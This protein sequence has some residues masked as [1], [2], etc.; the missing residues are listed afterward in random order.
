[1][2]TNVNE[3]RIYANRIENIFEPELKEEDVHGDYI[4]SMIEFV[5][6]KT[7]L[8]ECVRKLRNYCD[9]TLSNTKKEAQDIADTDLAIATAKGSSIRVAA[10]TGD[11]ITD[12][13]RTEHRIYEAYYIYSHLPLKFITIDVDGSLPFRGQ[14][15]KLDS[16]NVPEF[17]LDY[18]LTFYNE[19]LATYK[20]EETDLK[21]GAA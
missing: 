18:K 12:L 5:E 1:M 2:S 11:F 15:H 6:V 10:H 7:A 4:R 14:L 3:L 19:D 20:V 21:E 17:A 16:N 13:E 8:N 9:S